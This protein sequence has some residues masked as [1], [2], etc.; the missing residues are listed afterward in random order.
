MIFYRLGIEAPV[1]VDDTRHCGGVVFRNHPGSCGDVAG[2][3]ANTTRRQVSIKEIS[4]HRP[5]FSR[6]VE[7]STIDRHLLI[8]EDNAVARGIRG[9]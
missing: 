1:I 8:F 3:T 5:V 4:H 2:R 6:E 7:H 9:R